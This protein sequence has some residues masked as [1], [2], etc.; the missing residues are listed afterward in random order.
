MR[1]FTSPLCAPPQLRS[2]DH[3]HPGPFPAPAIHGTDFS[4]SDV[5]GNRRQRRSP[6][7]GSIRRHPVRHDSATLLLILTHGPREFVHCIHYSVRPKTFR[8]HSV[9]VGTR[10]PRLPAHR[11]LLLFH[12]HRL[13][14]ASVTNRIIYKTRLSGGHLPD[15]PARVSQPRTKVEHTKVA[16]PLRPAVRLASPRLRSSGPRRDAT[17]FAQHDATDCPS[18]SSATN[19]HSLLHRR[20]DRLCVSLSSPA[21]RCKPCSRTAQ[22]EGSRERTRRG[23][24]G[25]IFTRVRHSQRRCLGCVAVVKL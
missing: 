15:I 23:V 17:W 12:F 21:N 13:P 20:T 19:Q 4:I 10:Q 1:Q 25:T 14:D 11:L 24:K 3:P 18:S 6:E 2:T 16:S 9:I 22:V 5:R 7:P 8:R